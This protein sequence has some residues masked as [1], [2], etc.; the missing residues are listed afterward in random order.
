MIYQDALVRE[1]QEMIHAEELHPD[2]DYDRLQE[3]I[4]D[5][6]NNIMLFSQKLKDPEIQFVET[7]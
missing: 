6:Y 7:V 1:T 3:F 2:Y 5:K 4:K